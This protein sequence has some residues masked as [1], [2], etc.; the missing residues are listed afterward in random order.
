MWWLM[1]ASAVAG[2]ALSGLPAQLAQ[3]NTWEERLAA[4]QAI[5]DVGE[6]DGVRLGTA[7]EVVKLL[8]KYKA[9]VNAKTHWGYT[10]LH[11]A[12][13]NGHTLVVT[14]ISSR[15]M[16]EAASAAPMASSFS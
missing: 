2:D 8:L 16:S 13:K 11:L 15:G 6:V 14:K 4:V 9:D 12:S 1:I 3:L 7:L 10:A 5:A